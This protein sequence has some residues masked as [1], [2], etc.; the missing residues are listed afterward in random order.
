M[1]TVLLPW[2]EQ[3]SRVGAFEAVRSWYR[4]AFDEVDLRTVDSDDE[5]F[6]LSRCRNLGMA[7]I[8][9]PNEVVIINDA[10]TL[11]QLDAL[12]EAMDAAATSGLV[13]LPYTEYHWLGRTGS[14][15]YAAGVALPD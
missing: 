11:P 1:V 5:I 7:S 14:A 6:N 12:P 2:R 9:D 8:A 3:P 10:D 13:H 15:E 4:D